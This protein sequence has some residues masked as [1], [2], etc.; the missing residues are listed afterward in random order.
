MRWGITEQ[1]HTKDFHT[2]Q[3]LLALPA[4]SLCSRLQPSHAGAA[5][6]CMCAESATNLQSLPR[7]HHYPFPSPKYRTEWV[8]TSTWLMRRHNR[9]TCTQVH[10]SASWVPALETPSLLGLNLVNVAHYLRARS[11]EVLTPS[12]T[13]KCSTYVSNCHLLCSCVV[14]FELSIQHDLELPRNR[15]SMKDCLDQIDL[16]PCL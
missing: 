15:V 2:S 5:T 1:N 13:W 7:I 10:L 6:T 4:H 3:D 8:V 14:E 9:D 16:W 11:H 12:S